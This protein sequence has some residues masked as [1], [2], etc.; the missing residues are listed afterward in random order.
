MAV[1]SP[2]PKNNSRRNFL[3]TGASVTLTTS[4]YPALGAARVTD[5]AAQRQTETRPS[6]LDFELDWI[7]IASLQ[8]PLESRQYSARSVTE[9][10]LARIQ[11]IDKAGPM[12]NAVIEINPDALKIAEDL[13]QE[14]HAKGAR[15]PLHGIPLLIKDN[16]DTG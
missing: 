7:T 1:D 16:I 6:D 13:D 10:Y 5:Q 8:K 2:S 12:L 4:I 3:R 9:K 15:G 14:R 11:Q